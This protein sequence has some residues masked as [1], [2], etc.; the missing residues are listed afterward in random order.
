M[1]NLSESDLQMFKVALPII[2]LLG[3]IFVIK[4]EVVL[5]FMMTV[6]QKIFGILGHEATIQV[7]DKSKKIFMI[8]NSI[9]VVAILV[10]WAILFF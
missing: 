9:A 3:I 1:S 5:K 8:Y 7:T 2:A 10:Y 6:Q 4:A